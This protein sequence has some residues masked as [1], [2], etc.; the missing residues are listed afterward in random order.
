MCI[1]LVYIVIVVWVNGMFEAFLRR[2]EKA[3][4]SF[5][6]QIFLWTKSE[7]SENQKK[8]Q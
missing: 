3:F 2:N 5:L 1:G 4:Q 8:F 6:V 7:M